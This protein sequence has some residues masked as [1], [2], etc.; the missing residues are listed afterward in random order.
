[1]KKK[2]ILIICIL[3][4]CLN[5]AIGQELF[6]KKLENI[7]SD[8]NIKSEEEKL[9]LLYQIL[10]DY[11][12]DVSPESGTFWG[13]PSDNSRWT[14]YSKE[15]INQRKKDN[16]LFIN[17]LAGINRNN[18]N[19][20]SQLNYDLLK[21]QL[22]DENKGE[23]FPTELMP[24]NQMTGT[25]QQ[26][27]QTITFTNIKNE[28][29][30]ND[31]LKRLEKI[32]ALFDQIQIL[33]QEGL[34]QKI[35]P[36]KNSLLGVPEQIQNLIADDPSKS[37]FL[38]G[39][40]KYT[41]TLS[42]EKKKTMDDL[43]IKA[44]NE[45]VN[46][47]LR[48][49]KE[50]LEKTYIPNSRSSYGLKDLPNGINWYNYNIQQTTTTKLSYTE[51]HEIGLNEVKRIRT[52]MDALIKKIGFK[53]TFEEFGVFLKTDPQ[54][55]FETGDQL[56]DAYRVISK[57]IDPELPTLFG[58]LPRLPYGV[59]P[60]PSYDEKFQTTAYY[61]PGS[62]ESGRAGNF[63]VN[64]YDIKTRPKWE[65]EALTAHEAVPGHHLQI[66]LSQ[67]LENVP[68]LRKTSFYTAFVEGWGLY[69]E[70]LGSEIG[71]YK[72]PYSKYGQ[73]TYEMWRAIRLVVDTGIHGMGWSRQQAIDYFK[74]NSAKNEHDITV[75]VD[76]YI[77]WPGQALAYKIGELKIKEL[78][79]KATLELGDKFNVREF[80]DAIL[81]NGAV[82][83][84]I[85][86]KHINEWI[87]TVKNK[88]S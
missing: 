62:V 55:H 81:E 64:T 43:A 83:L 53:G 68:E 58:K 56:L 57:K 31:L 20:S 75:E 7:Q 34:K 17:A 26:V 37:D 30:A 4:N 18:L 79:K 39:Y 24:I 61:N 23:Q 50:Y 70:S 40:K 28:K 8:K 52:E 5:T 74:A 2:T 69:S 80:H 22:D 35:T 46:P 29:D 42:P 33:M 1:M 27:I 15:A 71:L 86:E 54:F 9:N 3:L 45:K 87:I 85:L 88:T 82:P 77:T 10:F 66:A 47:A 48:K 13:K 19:K 59:M 65:M 73:L 72:D 25:H 76:R 67:E 14:D 44:I 51:I 11:Q 41:A 60:V 32:P 78:R 84:N 21:N 36:S 63:Y 16:D 12:L 6:S 38:T 49:L